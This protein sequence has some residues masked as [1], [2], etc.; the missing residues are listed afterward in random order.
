M[1]AYCLI[2]DGEWLTDKH[3]DVFNELSTETFSKQNGVT[4]LQVMTLFK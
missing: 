1:D 3:I 4:T 2:T